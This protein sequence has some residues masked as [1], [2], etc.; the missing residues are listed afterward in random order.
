MPG[1]LFSMQSHMKK[2]DQ[3]G[4]ALTKIDLFVDFEL[5]RPE[6]EAARERARGRGKKSNAGRPPFD[7][8]LLLKMLVIQSLY[9][10]SDDATE[11]M[12]LDRL[13]FQRFLGLQIGDPVPDAKTLWLF[14]EAL[15]PGDLIKTLFLKFD[16]FLRENGFEAQ[17]GQIVDASIVKTRIRRDTRE[18]NEQVKNGDGANVKEWSENTR[19]Q[20]DLDARWTRK[21]NKNYHGYKNHTGADVKDKLIRQYDVTPASVHDSNVYD[22][23]ITENTD[24]DEYADSAYIS[25]ARMAKRTEAGKVPRFQEKGARGHPL[26]EGQKSANR[27]RARIRCRIEHIY[28]AQRQRA[29]DL[30]LRTV[31]II[32]ARVKIGL[33]NLA[34]NLE[35]YAFLKLPPRDKKVK[36]RVIVS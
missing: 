22:P 25:E 12:C 31:G 2:I 5:F 14:R 15:E 23:L 26:T 36:C 9:N 30:I 27:E 28:G 29:G 16:G 34:Y 21:N 20:K 3:N 32:H 8:I 17:Q 6:L 35:R 10:L 18:V 4:D 7:V 13:S 33:R 11:Q 19:R 24:P 1:S